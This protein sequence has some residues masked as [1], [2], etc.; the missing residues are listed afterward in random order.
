MHKICLNSNIYPNV[1]PNITPC[2]QKHNPNVLACPRGTKALTPQWWCLFYAES[3]H[4]G[5][6]GHHMGYHWMLNTSSID[7]NYLQ[8]ILNPGGYL[9]LDSGGSTV[10]L[11]DKNI[12]LYCRILNLQD[13]P[14]RISPTRSVGARWEAMFGNP[15]CICQVTVEVYKEVH[16]VWPPCCMSYSYLYGCPHW[17][18]RSCLKVPK[19]SSHCHTKRGM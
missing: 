6:Y 5:H 11:S 10:L 13:C 9:S 4:S 8:P 19:D 16:V 3:V 7:P 2:D 15:S 14:K 1:H 17:R 12:W 18:A